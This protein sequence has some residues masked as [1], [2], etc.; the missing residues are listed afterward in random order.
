MMIVL[1]YFLP[2][3]VGVIAF[4]ISYAIMDAVIPRG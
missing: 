2:G 4:A 3:I 1:E